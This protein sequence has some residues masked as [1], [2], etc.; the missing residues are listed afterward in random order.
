MSDS[1]RRGVRITSGRAT[2]SENKH[3]R[4][5]QGSLVGNILRLALPMVVGLLGIFLFNLADVFFVGKLGTIPLA[6]ISF[7]FPLLF[8]FITLSIAL[9]IAAT[10]LIAQAL[11]AG[12]TQE[13]YG[14]G[15]SAVLLALLYG[16]TLATLG[17]FTIEPVFKAMGAN[18]ETLPLI[19]TY[20]RIW[21]ASSPMLTLLIVVNHVL[22]AHG[23]AVF[24]GMVMLCASLM[25]IVLDP[26]LIFGLWGFP[27][28]EIA[29]AAWATLIA[30]AVG[31]LVLLWGLKH[32]K[33]L[34]KIRGSLKELTADFVRL[35]R[36]AIPASGQNIVQP[37]TE[38]YMVALLAGFGTQAVATYGVVTRLYAIVFLPYYAMAAALIPIVAQ[39]WG[40]T[41]RARVE[42][43]GRLATRAALLW[44]ALSTV[45]LFLFA[46]PIA[47]LF[48][49]GDDFVVWT[50]F[51]FR[52]IPCSFAFAGLVML[53]GSF[54]YGIA[55]PLYAFSSE[56]VHWFVLYVPIAYFASKWLGV[57]GIL[58]SEIV[59]NFASGLLA[60]VV[61]RWV[62]RKGF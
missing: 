6:A 57:E 24:P 53:L 22:R 45:P 43:A 15:S 7:V 38:I 29:G 42:E 5:T 34:G 8:G 16:I 59:A 10:A 32:Y 20:M 4:L 47:E 27:R 23:I 18:A 2:Q 35:I 3:A 30:R 31:C 19:K 36:F 13:A 21:Y 12:K 50:T 40:G 1:R 54:F 37:A 51:Y 49:N 62:C 44:G 41:H 55:K 46:R 61:Y 28:L 52:Y 48:G 56:A 11:G 26:L 14:L 33:I 25:N 60:F 39:N 17:F 58:L 9:G